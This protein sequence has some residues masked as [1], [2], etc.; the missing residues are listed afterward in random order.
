M[1]KNKLNILFVSGFIFMFQLSF[2]PP[3]KMIPDSIVLAF[4][5]GNATEL[6]KH[7]NTS[8]ELVILEEEDIYSKTQAEQIIRKF[9][10]DNKPS[11]FTVIFEGG[12][13]P[14][15]YAIGKLVTSTGPY[16]VYLLIKENEGSPL[17]HQIRIEAEDAENE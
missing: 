7:F 14:S 11:S 16:R 6:A 1:K 12:K 4:Q 13:E 17:I 5:A 9:F 8:I 2:A 3:A 15:K 10:S